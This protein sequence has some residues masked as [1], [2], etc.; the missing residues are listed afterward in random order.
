MDAEE[1]NSQEHVTISLRLRLPFLSF[2]LLLIAA[3]FL[4][5]RVWNTLLIGLGGMFVVAYLWVRQLAHGLHGK[6]KLHAQWVAVGDILRETFTLWNDSFIPALWVEVI[7]H[8]NVPGYQTAVVRSPGTNKKDFWHETAVCLQRGQYNL[9]PWTIRTGDPFGIF[10]C[11]RHYPQSNEIIIHPPIHSDLPFA[12]PAGQ[13]SGR[14]RARQR[15]LQATTNAATVRA[16]THGDPLRW[17]HWPSSAR[18]DNLF[19]RQFD[20]DATGDI[21]LLLDMDERVQYGEGLEGT[22]E[23]AVLLAAAFTAQCIHQS[24]AVGLAGY[25][26]VPQIIPT[27]S[28]TGQ[29]WRILRSLALIKADGSAS[30]N[31]SIDDLGLVANQGSAAIIITANP[32]IDWIPNL[33]HLAQKGI[34][35]NVVLLDRPSFGTTGN[36]RLQSQ[37]IQNL[38]INCQT[39]RRGDLN[40]HISDPKIEGNIRITPLGKA[41]VVAENR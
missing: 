29:Q 4:P 38:G 11:T 5:D 6:R 8:S 10:T 20:L 33:L 39:V 23:I 19:V 7:D 37:S 25:G 32:E 36:T 9:G 17:I 16:Y 28:G 31:A 34:E 18:R 27:G 13:S 35:S 21:W 12:L 24:R 26:R 40:V 3:L 2:I 22:E 1:E 30:L 15:S 14:K 41:V